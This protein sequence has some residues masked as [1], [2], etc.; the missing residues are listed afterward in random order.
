M[1]RFGVQLPNFSGVEA[2][3]L[4]EHVAGLTARFE[5]QR[6]PEIDGDALVPATLAAA[7]DV[8][9]A[10]LQRV[11]AA[12]AG[13]AAERVHVDE[14]GHALERAVARHALGLVATAAGA[15]RLGHDH[16]YRSEE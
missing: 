13:S 5:P 4:F 1:T 11:E 7:A 14:A 15:E 8:A 3:E 16:G 6:G 2:A 9:L 10:P 12:E